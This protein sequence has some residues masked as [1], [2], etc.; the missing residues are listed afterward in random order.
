M[1]LYYQFSNSKFDYLNFTVKLT[2]GVKAD[3]EHVQYS[4]CKVKVE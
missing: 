3:E 1:I 4:V 2:I